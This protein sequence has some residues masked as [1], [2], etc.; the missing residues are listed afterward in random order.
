[1]IYAAIA[2]LFALVENSLWP[3]LDFKSN[4]TAKA[5]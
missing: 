1:M 3:L 2:F 4:W 5:T